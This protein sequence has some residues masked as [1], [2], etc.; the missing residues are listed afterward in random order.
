MFKIGFCYPFEWGVATLTENLR[1]LKALGYD[2]IEL[3]EQVIDQVGDT[4]ALVAALRESGIACAQLCPYFNFVDGDAIYAA[5][6]VKARAYLDLAQQTGCTLIRVFTGKPWGEGVVGAYQATEAQWTSAIAGLQAICDMAKPLGIRYALECHTG[7][8]MED[9]PSTLRLLQGVN[10][11][12]LLL[13]LQLPLAD[14]R[15]PIDMSLANLGRYT[16]HMHA[17]NFSALIGGEQLPLAEGVIDYSDLL[18]RLMVMGFD[19]YVS[20][21]HATYGGKRDPWV[22]AEGEA[23]YLRALQQQLR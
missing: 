14:G 15:E 7:S 13:N 2:G 11:P 5:T 19:G 9:T 17:H 8:L 3:W 20:I 4:E 1:R 10:R 22:I 12:N 23:R 18:T 16:C 21:E 6:M